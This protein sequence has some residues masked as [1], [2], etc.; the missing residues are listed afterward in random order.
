M[1]VSDT[2]VRNRIS[3]V[4][5]GIIILVMGFYAY[6]E[7]P[8]EDEPD[9]TIP[10][11]F[12]STTYKGVA[13]SDIETAVTIPIEKKLKGLEGIKSIKSVSAEGVSNIS[14]EFVPGTIIDDVLQK[15]KDKVDEAKRELP[16]D[17]EDDP[18]DHRGVLSWYSQPR[19]NKLREA[20]SYGYL[21]KSRIPVELIQKSAGGKLNIRF[22]VD[23]G[24]PG[25]LAIYG[26]R[27][28]KYALDPI[29]G[30]RAADR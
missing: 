26:K 1:I 6:N 16:T 11:V 14:I 23:E 15:V 24:M 18:A 3:V 4:V 2:A 17:L 13:S 21:C 25:G 19:D 20:G 30:S 7:L 29:F 8:R 10:Y 28:G 5:L 9:I 22:E 27:F 12:V